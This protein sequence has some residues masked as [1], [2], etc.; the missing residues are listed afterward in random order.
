MS[1][2]LTGEVLERFRELT[3]DRLVKESKLTEDSVRYSLYMAL[4]QKGGISDSE[5][6]VGYPHP[7]IER[8][9]ID[10]Y[11]PTSESHGAAAWELKYDRA[12]PSKKN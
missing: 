5:I 12:F 1:M 8:A 9:K 3:H 11:S 7:T 4:Q 10:S 6:V 2:I